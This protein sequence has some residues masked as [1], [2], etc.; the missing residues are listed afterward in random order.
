MQ[1]NVYQLHNCLLF[2]S[3]ETSKDTN[4]RS[5]L[6]PQLLEVSLRYQGI[7]INVDPAELTPSEMT[8]ATA[9][10]LERLIKCG[11]ICEETLVMALNRLSV[12]DMDLIALTIEDV[13]G[14]RLNWAPLVKGWLRPTGETRLD[15]LVTLIF[16][17]F[18]SSYPGTF[19]PC[20]H[21]IP[22]GTFPLNRYNGCPFCGR[23]FE[24]SS[25]VYTGQ[26][27]RLKPLRLITPAEMKKIY[28]GLLES[29]TPLDATSLSSALTMLD[30]FGIPDGV[31]VKMKETVVNLARPL[32]ARSDVGSLSKLLRTPADVMR[33]LWLDHTDQSRLIKPSTLLRLTVADAATMRRES[34]EVIRIRERYLLGLHYT[35]S[36]CRLWATVI[37]ATTISAAKA[38]ETMHPQRGMWVRFIRALRLGEM[39]RRPGMEKLHEILDRFYRGDYDVWQGE[40]NAAIARRDTH[41]ALTL[42]SQRPGSFARQLFPAMLKLGK[43]AVVKAFDEVAADVPMRLL[44]SLGAYAETYFT[45]PERMVRPITGRAITV[46]ANPA[47]V[48]LDDKSR[49]EIISAVNSLVYTK[50][51]Q[52]FASK[53]APGRT[54]YI[55]PQLFNVPIAIGDRSVTVQDTSAAVQ[56][57]RFP[58]EG[59]KLRLFMQWGK[60]LPAQHL[61]MDLSARLIFDEGP[62]D[63]LTYY[64]LTIDGGQ[65]SGDIREIPDCVGTAEYIEL[66]VDRLAERHVLYV[67]FSCNAYSSGHISPALVVGWMDSANPMKVSETTGVAY[68]PSTVIFQTSVPDN[69]LLK[70][71]VFGYLDVK[72]R[73]VVWLEMPFSGQLAIDMNLD[74]IQKLIHRLRSKPTIGQCLTLMAEARG[75][76]VTDDPATAEEVYIDPTLATAAITNG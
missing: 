59:S 14:L 28:I 27:T 26:G 73:E 3:M 55:E 29:G 10:L 66:D 52:V 58:L 41:R 40:V 51:R 4:T 30:L 47:T 43:D 49:D 33:F 32:A 75:M 70:G 74:V 71:L 20:G 42:L 76:T 50:I 11:Y 22:E 12:E 53:P 19:L 35:R 7:C 31:E 69:N 9:V 37:N 56:G 34:P 45:E 18:P 5:A 39:A 62:T 8:P 15:H 60:G 46:P 2:L 57:M 72:T 1:F 25:E 67:V 16:N 63:D 64:N 17:I 21:F 36:Q 6:T 68:D 13:M 38:C 48:S 23:Q 44:I 24:T 54:I 61:D 65:H